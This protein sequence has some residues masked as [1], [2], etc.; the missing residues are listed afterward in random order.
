MRPWS[1]PLLW[2]HPSGAVAC[3]PYFGN[4]VLLDG[5]N[6]TNGSTTSVDESPAAHGAATFTGSN[7]LS[8]AQVKF[9]TASLLS[10]N[11]AGAGT[12]WPASS[13]FDLSTIP[14][15][16][17]CWFYGNTIGGNQFLISKWG[18]GHNEWILWINVT[19]LGFRISTNGVT[20]I[21]VVLAGTVTA[22]VWH[23]AAVDFD[24]TTYRLYLDG[25]MT[26][27]STTLQTIFVSTSNIGI[28]N[29]A[30]GGGF[31]LNGYI[32]EV[33][34]TKGVARY[35]RNVGFAVPTAAFPRIACPPACDPYFGNVVLLMGYEGANGATSG[36]GM[37]DESP[38]AHGAASSVTLTT[39]DTSQF[40]FGA[41]SLHPSNAAGDIQFPNSTDWR[42]STANSDQFTIECWFR[43]STSLSSDGQLVGWGQFLGT[44]HSW[45]FRLK[46]TG[47]M[48]FM[49]ST[50][51][52]SF[53][54]DI[55]TSGAAITTG[56][57][58]FATVDKDATGKIRIY[59]NGVMVGSSTPANSVMFTT[60]VVLSILAPP[61]DNGFVGWLDELRI[62]KGVARYASDNPTGSTWNP[63]DK[64]ASITLSGGNL[65]ATSSGSS[66][67]AVRGNVGHTSGKW[68]VE[69]QNSGTWSGGTNIGL[70][71]ASSSAVLSSVG[72]TKLQAFI[73]I[74]YNGEIWFNGVDTTK[75]LLQ[76]T[77]SSLI[78]MA[79]DLD[80]KTAWIRQ[81]TNNWNGDAAANPVTNTGGVDI[82]SVFNG[83]VSA[84]PLMCSN[85]NNTINTTNFGGSTPFT[86]GP[87]TGF[88][89]WGGSAF[90]VPTAAF[91]RVACTGTS[92]TWS[93]SDKST[94]ITLS[95]GNLTATNGATSDNAVR[96]AASRST[97]KYYVEFTVTG[98][99][100]GADT[101]LGIATSAAVL[102]SFGSNATQG[103]ACFAGA[104]Q[105][106]FNGSPTG[107]SSSGTNII[108]TVW[109]IAVDLVNSK[110][111]FR[112]NATAWNGSG[113][114]NPA[115]NTGGTNIA[116]LFPTNAAYAIFCSNG[117]AAGITAN[118]GG[119]A[120]SFTP[121]SGFTAW[122]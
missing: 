11:T 118:F 57:W 103:V 102:T 89:P 121:P 96:S 82:S 80:N 93:T 48:E 117:S 72:N 116:A 70:G 98:A 113:T 8:T 53:A 62:T 43:L 45:S 86:N 66:D 28:G 119:S 84:Y 33:R 12:T 73:C 94:N 41:S 14:F 20:T 71:I 88:Q 25:V 38:A 6:G 51:G 67:S 30:Y 9:G 49:L 4:V 24:G 31:I 34:I 3:D 44:P 1:Q 101:G 75:T 79:I 36:P 81:G 83:S 69:F 104:G 78:G 23:H 21:D 50:D 2:P 109:S 18:G 56:V 97:G 115:T 65:V 55:I 17:E 52:T 26:G 74:A 120:F 76:Y 35:A 68:Y 47:E 27:S 92:S 87:P 77:A 110:I 100:V 61:G 42:L 16:I 99:L 59:R 112:T 90:A 40:K 15:T 54:V 10:S 22:A 13:D 39:I 46:T 106:W 85:V 19:T 107:V 108:G 105:I 7:V 64:S 29:D 122:G 37:T 91:P 5:F 95:N 114:D 32:D 111:W 60:S 63:S 58:Y